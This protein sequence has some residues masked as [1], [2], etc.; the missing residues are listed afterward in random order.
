VSFEYPLKAG[1]AANPKLPPLSGYQPKP[2]SPA[3]L[4][5]GEI[6]KQLLQQAGLI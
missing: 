6:A 2:F 5:T 1:V 3:D 4:G